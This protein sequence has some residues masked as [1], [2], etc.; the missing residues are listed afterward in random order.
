MLRTVRQS[1]QGNRGAGTAPLRRPGAVASQSALRQQPGARE[2]GVQRD[3]APAGVVRGRPAAARHPLCR[4]DVNAQLAQY[5]DAVKQ[6]FDAIVPTLKQISALQHEADF[7]ARARRIARDGLGFE[8]PP[9]I[10]A[11]AWVE[12]LD[13]RRLFAWCV[14]QTYSRFC[15]DFFGARPTGAAEEFEEFL[16]S[17]GFHSMDISPCADGRLAHLVRYVLR[18][19]PRAVRRKSYAGAMFD[20]D[21]SVRKWTEVE[22]RRYREGKPNAADA[23]TRYLKLAV[24]HFSSGAPER[25]GCAA[26]GSDTAQAAQAALDRLIAFRQAIENS[27]CC[28][29]SIDLLLIG[30]DTDCDAIRIHVP[31]ETGEMA[32]ERHIDSQRLY[33]ETAKLS[34]AAA[35]GS[36]EDAVRSCSPGVAAGMANLIVRLVENNLSQIDYVRARHGVAYPDIGHA[37]RFIGAGVGFEDVQLRNLMYFAY[38][39]TVE[40]GAA[41]IDVGIRIFKGLNV[42]H[43]LPVPVVVRF[44][45]HG[46]VPGARDR[47][48]QHCGRVAQALTTRYADLHA[49]GLLH[50]LQAVRDCDTAAA[51]EIIAC[52]VDQPETEAH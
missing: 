43:G 46:V 49:K 36:I 6:A 27:Y 13:M 9:A 5:E 30:L 18:L 19:S 52:S 45:Y 47:A 42:R 21:D 7:E 20:V 37:E 40:D 3:R 41:D 23:P 35:A 28:G 24:Y 1:Q 38:L 11:A 44:D 51:L 8:L 22:L 12:Q 2:H 10:L 50:V 39:D 26:H 15:N 25:E 31:D 32:L 34:A 14:F 29:A 33:D 4:Q 16:R 17:C 48:V